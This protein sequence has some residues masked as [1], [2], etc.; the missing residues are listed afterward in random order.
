[1]RVPVAFPGAMRLQ[2]S[3]RTMRTPGHNR[4][5]FSVIPSLPRQGPVM[6]KILMLDCKQ[7][8][9]SFNPLASEFEN[10]HIETAEALYQ[11]RGLNTEL[12]GALKVF[13]ARPDLTVLPIVGAR[14]GSAGLL[15]ASGWQRHSALVL[16]E[17]A[18]PIDSAAA[19][20]ASV[21]GAIG[22]DSKLDPE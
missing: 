5:A 10:F 8:I 13:E 15:S 19:V 16:G 4:R 6:P 22:A 9:S 12:G 2:S 7:E 1:E 17:V 3:W 14:A 18:K 11:H 21:H 20:Y